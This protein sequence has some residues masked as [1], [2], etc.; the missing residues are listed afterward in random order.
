MSRGHITHIK[1]GQGQG[2]WP[3]DCPQGD[4]EEGE[5]KRGEV[6][7]RW[8]GRERESEGGERLRQGQ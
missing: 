7:E 6:Y 4:R 8:G 5:R 3:L 1:G 2:G